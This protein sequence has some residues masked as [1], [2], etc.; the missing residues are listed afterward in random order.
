MGAMPRPGDEDFTG[1]FKKWI[2][3]PIGALCCSQTRRKWGL[4]FE[5]DC[6]VILVVLDY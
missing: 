4:G 1:E 2:K 5:L 6:H 3:V